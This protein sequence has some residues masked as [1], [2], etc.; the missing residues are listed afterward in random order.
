[1]L[2]APSGQGTVDLLITEP[3]PFLVVAV[4]ELPSDLGG[5]TANAQNHP[6]AVF[7]SAGSAYHTDIF[8]GRSQTF[9][10]SGACMPP[11][12]LFTGMV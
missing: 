3:M 2:V 9:E 6:S 1:M 4:H 10:C 7:D 12:H 8:P 11:K 5:S